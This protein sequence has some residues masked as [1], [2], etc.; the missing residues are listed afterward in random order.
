ML[1]ENYQKMR[2]LVPLELNTI[3][4]L[5]RGAALSFL[6]TRFYD[7]FNIL[8]GSFVVKKDP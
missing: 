8:L 2:T 7:W 4:P 3:V 6:L 5:A 1:L